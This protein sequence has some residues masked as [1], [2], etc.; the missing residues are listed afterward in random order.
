VYDL[1]YARTKIEN[2]PS[3]QREREASKVSARSKTRSGEKSFEQQQDTNKTAI[4]ITS[5]S[6]QQKTH[7]HGP[8][9]VNNGGSIA[10]D[11]ASGW[12]VRLRHELTKFF[13]QWI[14]DCSLFLLLVVD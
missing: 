1:T 3:S 4:I 14:R 13:W 5:S 7:H 9:H 12:G 11:I 10:A 2:S 8:S 6:H